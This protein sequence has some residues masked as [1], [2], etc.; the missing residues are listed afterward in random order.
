MK[1]RANVQGFLSVIPTIKQAFHLCLL[2]LLLFLQSCTI[3]TNIQTSRN[4]DHPLPLKEDAFDYL[5]W[6][7]TTPRFLW[8]QIDFAFSLGI[9]KGEE[10]G[11]LETTTGTIPELQTDMDE[12]RLSSRWFPLEQQIEIIKPYV[13]FGMGYYDFSLLINSRGDYIYSDYFFSDQPKEVR[14]YEIDKDVK[15]LASGLFLFFQ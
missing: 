15:V 13:G 6:E 12:V 10:E 14:Y 8:D 9:N 3:K 5:E 2:L 4:L 11:K 1:E 7:V